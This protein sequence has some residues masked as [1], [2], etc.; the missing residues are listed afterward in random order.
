MH[1]QRTSIVKPIVMA[2]K[3]LFLL[4][5]SLLFSVAVSQ[6]SAKSSNGVEFELIVRQR[7]ADVEKYFEIT[8]DTIQILTGNK[9]SLFM[10]NFGLEIEVV[11]ADTQAAI[12]SAQLVTIGS[13]PFNMAEKYRVE[14][15][16]PAR[17][18][19]I[20][21]K[22]RSRYQ[23]LIS[24]RKRVE[25]D[26]SS[27]PIEIDKAG[28][29]KTDPSANFDFYFVKN[30]LADYH[31]NNIKNY[32]ESDH[33]RFREALDI[34]SPGKVNFY[35]CPCLVNSVRWDK[36]FG[37]MIDPGRLSIFTIYNHDYSSIDPILPNMLKLLRLWGYAPPFLVE[38]LAGYFDFVTY[39]MRKAKAAS[40][41]PKIRSLLTT[42]EY[43][44]CDP[45]IAEL[46]AA[47]FVKF[48]ADSFG[49][50]KV[51]EVYEM[52]DDLTLLRNLEKVF[53]SPIDSLESAWSNYVDTAALSRR[54]F[55]YYASRAGALFD[56]KKQTEYYEEMTK[57][58]Q[59]RK[60]SVDTWRKLAQIYYQCGEY[61]KALDG[62][63]RLIKIDSNLSVY[64]QI[65]ANL[66]II[67]G[68]YDVGL[69]ESDTVLAHDSTYVSSQLLKARILAIKGD[70]A[71]ALKLAEDFY[72][73]EKSMAGKIEFLLFLGK[74]Y[75]QKGKCHNADTA[76]Q[77]FT[78]ALAWSTEM[79]SKAPDD[80]INKLR[81]GLACLGLKEFGKASDY[82]KMAE[83]TESRPLFLGE[84]LIALGNLEDLRSNHREAVVYYQRALGFPLSVYQH[85][86]C[87]KYIDNPYKN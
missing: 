62:Y 10:V 81:A 87:I 19:N 49:I 48:L 66:Y 9:I 13:Q 46:T 83:F 28:E 42:S 24:P 15:N 29:F 54:L 79:I 5:L 64:H 78:D 82:L 36:R 30:S 85:D 7:P 32:I 68:K 14:Y 41:L 55:D 67:N 52:S 53:S 33:K 51:K 25:I 74:I 40:K 23:L 59:S 61:Y 38:G 39:E 43:Y 4:I 60:D 69:K 71:Q 44:S 6:T 86:V 35:L 75:S 37:Y 34:S 20:P 1:P 70:T 26:T 65:M 45:R 58:D 27:C 21:G 72:Q 12:F 16:L 17:M 2:K 31:W 80:P 3:Y 76:R 50:N 56:F 11:S 8:R 84:I 18:E 57:Y 77:N 47:S 22:N 63:Q 73:A